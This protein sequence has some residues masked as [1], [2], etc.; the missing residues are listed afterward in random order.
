MGLY[1]S[2]AERGPPDEPPDGPTS[3]FTAKRRVDHAP[4]AITIAGRYEVLALLGSGGM[5]I[6][7]T[8]RDR[9]T[10]RVIAVKQP[11]AG[12][13]RGSEPRLDPGVSLAREHLALLHL[14]HPNI[15]QRHDFGVDERGD[16][17]LV[18]ELVEEACSIVTYARSATRV[19]RI[20]ALVQ[21]F[22]ALAYVH[23]KGMLHR[24]V[25]P[26]NILVSRASAPR[27][28]DST[29]APRVCLIDFGLTANA[30]EGMPP[31]PDAVSV[32]WPLA[33]SVLYLAPELIR[34]EPAS[35]ASELYA[36]GTVAAEVMTGVHPL[37]S[38]GRRSTLAALE[39]APRQWLRAEASALGLD[40]R[41]AELLGR[42]LAREPHERCSSAEE[43]LG[44]LQ[45]LL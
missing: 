7:H 29:Q 34:G 1:D 6:V 36:A 18:L 39:D 35:V 31:H 13:A 20:S 11:C 15:V 9:L 32:P 17:F 33:G 26:T 38:P 27:R 43:V 14:H 42:L 44:G 16:F 21:M 25:K 12:R 24:D 40:S 10:G 2:N 8:A 30:Q 4:P 23:R 3:G 19:Q 41:T 37:G 5:G 28:V 45:T 22:E